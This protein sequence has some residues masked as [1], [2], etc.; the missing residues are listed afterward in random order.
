MLPVAFD[1]YAS[2]H[3][4]GQASTSFE[5]APD[6][7]VLRILDEEAGAWRV[8]LEL[9]GR[10]ERHAYEVRTVEAPRGR[11][12]DRRTLG[13]A[14]RVLRRT[15][16]VAPGGRLRAESPEGSALPFAIEAGGGR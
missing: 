5:E 9:L 16:L 12:A 6:G 15:F 4:T 1:L 11:A 14:R 7:T 2:N 3:E 8:A 10:A 13:V